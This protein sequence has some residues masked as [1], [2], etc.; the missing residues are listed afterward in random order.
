MENWA[1]QIQWILANELDK[2]KGQENHYM[3]KNIWEIQ[4]LYKDE[5]QKRLEERKDKDKEIILIKPYEV[6]TTASR[7]TS[8]KTTK[9]SF[10]HNKIKNLE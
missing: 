10:I 3:N 4:D 2:Y 8:F 1:Y 7:T 6:S 9:S 5:E